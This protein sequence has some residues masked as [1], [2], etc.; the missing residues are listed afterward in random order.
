M[1]FLPKEYFDAI[2]TNLVQFQ[3]IK[4][5][6]YKEKSNLQR[7]ETKITIASSRRPIK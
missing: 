2:I 7:L 3:A 4:T 6:E 1:A 5:K